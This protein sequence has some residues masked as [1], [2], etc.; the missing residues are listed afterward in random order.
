MLRELRAEFYQAFQTSFW[1]L[2]IEGDW[3][4]WDGV[5][6][7]GGDVRACIFHYL[8]RAILLFSRQFFSFVRCHLLSLRQLLFVSY[9]GTSDN[10]S[11]LYCLRSSTS[12]VSTLSKRKKITQAPTP[13]RCQQLNLFVLGVV[14]FCLA[15]LY[16]VILSL[17]P[18]RLCFAPYF[19]F[20]SRGGLF[21]TSARFLLSWNL[22]FFCFNPEQNKRKL[23]KLPCLVPAS[24]CLANFVIWFPGHI[25]QFA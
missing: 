15:Q 24:Y 7:G 5:T 12:F 21:G 10:A 3:D 13:G 25:E 8:H 1:T 6:R 20:V 18:R 23:F 2:K 11:R 4:K 17:F 16:Y 19:S 22:E 14:L 9:G